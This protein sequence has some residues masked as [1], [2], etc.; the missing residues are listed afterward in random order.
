MFKKMTGG[1]QSN[2]RLFT[3]TDDTYNEKNLRE[4]MEIPNTGTTWVCV[5]P[6][7]SVAR[8]KVLHTDA[9]GEAQEVPVR[10]KAL[11]QDTLSILEIEVQTGDDGKV[12][13]FGTFP[14]VVL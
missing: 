10:K 6:L 11:T 12:S 8:L 9:E 4:V 14:G 2:T 1:V 5:V 13:E 7:N 3:L